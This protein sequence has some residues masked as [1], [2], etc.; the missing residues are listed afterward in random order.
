VVEF[1]PRLF[2]ALVIFAIGWILGALLER[3]VEAIFKGLKVDA[4]LKSAGFEDV[5]KRA[6][7]NL[8]SGLFVGA[9]VKWFIIVVFLI[10]SFDML[11]LNRVTD[12]LNEVVGYLP[13]VI[14]AVLILIVAVIVG[15]ALQKIVVASARAAHV[16]MAEL[17][18]RVTKWTVWILAILTALFN[19]GIAPWIQNIITAVVAGAA[20]AFGLAFGLGG[21]DAASK[22]IEK[23]IRAVEEKE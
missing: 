19:L 5:V 4:G 7:H 9:I 18:G 14:A 22:A 16:K 20:L 10:A 15:S 2:F 6:G 3:L 17:L 11:H 23:T 1:I 21:K 12:F 13:Q 8:N